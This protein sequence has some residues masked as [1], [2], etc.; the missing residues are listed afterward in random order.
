MA[1][2]HIM[3]EIRQH[4]VGCILPPIIY[5]T[6]MHLTQPKKTTVY[7]EAEDAARI[8]KIKKA[9]G[10]TNDAPAIRYAIRNVPL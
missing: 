9:I 7:L 2:R 8:K 5:T 4:N 3:Q 6:F 1:S 10:A